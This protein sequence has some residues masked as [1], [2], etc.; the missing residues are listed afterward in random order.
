MF[1]YNCTVH[2]VIKYNIRW[3]VCTQS[4]PRGLGTGHHGFREIRSIWS[5]IPAGQLY[6]WAIRRG[7]QL[8][9]RTLHRGC[10]IGGFRVRCS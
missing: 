1:R 4:D 3:Q 8:G 7:Q 2:D 6:F 5:D 10:R 9:K